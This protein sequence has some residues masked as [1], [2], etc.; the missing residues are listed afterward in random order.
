M[1]DEMYDDDELR[2]AYEDENDDLLTAAQMFDLVTLNRQKMTKV[3]VQIK[4]KDEDNVELDEVVEELLKY[5]VSKM[6]DETG[7]NQFVNQ[8]LPLMAQ[9]VVSG[10]LRSTGGMNTA[11]LLSQDITRTSIVNMMCLSF[12]MLK[13]MQ[14]K[15]LSV[16]TQEFPVTQEEIDEIDR[17]SKISNQ[18]TVAALAGEDPTEVIQRMKN[19]G[20]I[21]D[22]DLKELMG[23]TNGKNEDKGKN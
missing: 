14:Q 10:L 15:D 9:S 12:L 22:E 13:F 4:D 17:R 3:K 18:L 11:F 20:D 2:E 21:S 5:V 19:S 1:T 23:D 6:K 7:D 8:I 16:Y